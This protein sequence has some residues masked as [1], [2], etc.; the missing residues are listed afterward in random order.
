MHTHTH[1]RTH[2]HTHIHT[3]SDTH[4]HTHT[5]THTQR[6]TITSLDLQNCQH[7]QL[8]DAVDCVLPLLCVMSLS[9]IKPG[10]YGIL[11]A[12]SNPPAGFSSCNQLTDD[13][14][15]FFLSLSLSLP[16]S[17]PSLC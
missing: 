17:F 1:T 2:T 15:G 8:S 7:F 12:A 5:H 6:Q 3:H 10:P 13:A 9:Q 14:P 4:T 16:F 11:P